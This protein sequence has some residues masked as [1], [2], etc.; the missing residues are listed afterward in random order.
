MTTPS[1]HTPA[2]TSLFP[3]LLETTR[4]RLRE[5]QPA[6]GDALAAYWVRSEYQRFYPEAIDPATDARTLVGTLIAAQHNTPRTVY[7]LAI[8]LRDAPQ[9]TAIGTAGV[10][11]RDLALREADMGYELHP[12]HWGSGYAT[13]AAQA[14]LTFAFQTL[15]LHRVWAECNA[16]NAGSAHVLRKV[17]MRQEAHFVEATYARGQWW[18]E[19]RFAIL[20]HE[21]HTLQKRLASDA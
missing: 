10:R 20:D 4:L 14:M 12:D 7:Q 19:L 6:D 21:W 9:D 16:A 13:E 18:D 8:T 3:V 5:F 1:P 15:H 17:G 2:P 11:I